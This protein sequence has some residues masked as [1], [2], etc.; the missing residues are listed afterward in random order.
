M[1]IASIK[2]T[3]QSTP[4]TLVNLKEFIDL[5]IDIGKRIPNYNWQWLHLIVT[6]KMVPQ[7]FWPQNSST[8]KELL[9]LS[10]ILIIVI[11]APLIFNH[12]NGWRLHKLYK[13]QWIRWDIEGSW[14]RWI[15][16]FFY[17][18]ELMQ[19]LH[20]YVCWCDCLK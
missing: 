6:E 20:I 3:E 15:M 11:I 2:Y 4:K 18:K 10:N 5:G 13:P 1:V 7:N 19:C 8:I 9:S 12:I 16:T 17:R 14:L